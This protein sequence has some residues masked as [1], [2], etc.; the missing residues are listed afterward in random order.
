MPGPSSFV[1]AYEADIW[2]S[3]PM[4]RRA[5]VID[6]RTMALVALDADV[7]TKTIYRY[8]KGTR[9]S[10]LRRIAVALAKHGRPDLVNDKMGPR[11]A[12]ET[13]Q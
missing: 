1:V 6:G 12:P 2:Q 8:L 7:S 9:V 11:F 13:A 4:T 5:S 10:G 3:P